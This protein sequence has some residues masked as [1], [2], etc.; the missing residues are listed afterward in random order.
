[1]ER[2]SC[3]PSGAL[4]FEVACRFLEILHFHELEE[5]KIVFRNL[6]VQSDLLE[7]I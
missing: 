1:M 4:I 6:T 5:I 2:A 7:T 3:H